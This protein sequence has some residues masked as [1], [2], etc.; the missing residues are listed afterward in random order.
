MSTAPV[1]TVFVR[2]SADCKYKDD[3]FWKK[4]NCRKHLRWTAPDPKHPGKNKQF[5]IK[6]GTRAWAVA[7]ELKWKKEAQFEGKPTTPENEQQT[8]EAAIQRFLDS[9]RVQGIDAQVVKKYERELERLSA[10]FSKKSKLFVSEI[11][12]EYL[13]EFRGTWAGLYPSS[14]TRQQVQTRL[15]GFLRYCFDARWLDRIPRLSPIHADE[16]PTLPFSPKDYELILD[17]IPGMFEDSKA[18]RVRALVQL[19]RYSGLNNPGC[20]DTPPV[21]IAMGPSEENPP[22]HHRKAEDRH[23]RECSYSA[24]SWAGIVGGAE[25]ASRIFFLVHR[26]RQG[27]KRRDQLAA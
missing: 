9:K 21:R 12:L 1:I 19:M 10:F 18:K 4:C 15:R 8:I 24:R 23:A 17:T 20:C 7:E 22:C 3:E 11:R 16:P 13:D 14:A 25:R 6:A 27:A 5:R 2:H 26:Q